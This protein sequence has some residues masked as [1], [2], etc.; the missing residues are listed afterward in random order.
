M[1]NI[2]FSPDMTRADYNRVLEKVGSNFIIN[3]KTLRLEHELNPSI[4]SYRF[5]L[6]ENKG[7][8]RPLEIKLNKNDT[9]FLTHLALGIVRQDTSTTPKQYANFPIFTYPDSNY[10][11]GDDTS[12]P[13][14]FRALEALYNGLLS[15]KTSPTERLRD[16]ATNMFKYVP[17][18]GYLVAAGSQ[19]EDEYPQY[20]ANL[21]EKGF[22]KLTP[23]IILNG[24]ENNSFDLTLGS[25]NTA[26]IDGHVNAS[27][28][29]VNTRNVVVLQMHGFEVVNGA[30]AASRWG[31]AF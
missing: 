14:E 21:E 4:N 17:E 9:F 28:A 2:I 12:N 6:S 11:T 30:T 1:S 8:D 26:L 13:E 25:G 3:Q 7:S 18:R 20:G 27:N 24:Q 16:F 5:E 29:A 22:F 31:N 23:N 15:V 10:F 19:T